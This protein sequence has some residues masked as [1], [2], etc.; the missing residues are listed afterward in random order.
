M[1]GALG[2]YG[3]QHTAY[4]GDGLAHGGACGSDSRSAAVGC[5]ITEAPVVF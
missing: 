5:G 3:L 2:V 4:G 1:Q